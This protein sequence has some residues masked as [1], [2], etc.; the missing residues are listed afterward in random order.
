MKF[1]SQ[2]LSVV[3][4]LSNSGD[5]KHWA[6]SNLFIEQAAGYKVDWIDSFLVKPVQN[7]LTN[8][9]DGKQTCPKLKRA[10]F[11]LKDFGGEWYE[12]FRM[13]SV[14][15]EIGHCHVKSFTASNEGGEE[16]MRMRSSE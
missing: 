7:W 16:S 13:D 1:L 8:I 12:L 11:R 14:M 10:T 4:L 15:E 5:N 9:V 6:S 3:I 2:V